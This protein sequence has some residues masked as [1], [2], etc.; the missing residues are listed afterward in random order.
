MVSFVNKSIVENVT[1]GQQPIGLAIEPNGSQ[2]FVTCGRIN[3]VS[4]IDT[5][6]GS[7]TIPSPSSSV[8]EFSWL[9]ILPI[10]LTIP[11]ALVVVRKRGL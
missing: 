11:I 7:S 1:V 6:N 10:L 8:P 2:V 9:T 4:V 3:S 5:T